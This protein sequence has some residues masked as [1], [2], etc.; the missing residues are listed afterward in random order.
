M[1]YFLV[2]ERLIQELYSDKT[3][4]AES[5]RREP[6][7][8]LVAPS[9][10]QSSSI[11]PSA[12]RYAV[13]ETLITICTRF[14][15]K[16]LLEISRQTWATLLRYYLR[17]RGQRRF[18]M[19]FLRLVTAGFASG[20]EPVVMSMLL[21]ENM[22]G[23]LWEIVQQKQKEKEQEKS[24]GDPLFFGIAEKLILLL[25]G[26]ENDPRYP[27]MNGQFSVNMAWKRIRE[28]RGR[29]KD[30]F[31]PLSASIVLSGRLS[32]GVLN[33]ERRLRNSR[34]R[35]VKIAIPLA[36]HMRTRQSTMTVPEI[37]TRRG[38]VTATA[39]GSTAAG[40]TERSHRIRGN[41]VRKAK[42]F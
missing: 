20:E 14:S 27:V 29:N 40:D 36:G 24:K 15:P 37:P 6:R 28:S 39:R 5:P 21:F 31:P 3:S 1:R 7:I 25:E 34:S 33:S 38:S 16:Y 30:M 9:P 12:C 17:V 42:K 4:T 22:I 19:Q 13:L 2:L 23:E 11:H 10:R 26:I 8:A 41:S 32:S 18:H 35:A